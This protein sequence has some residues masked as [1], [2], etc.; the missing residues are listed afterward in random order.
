M[1][2][3]SVPLAYLLFS[4]LPHA[5]AEELSIK[6]AINA[7]IEAMKRGDAELAVSLVYQPVGTERRTQARVRTLTQKAKN[8]EGSPEYVD[9]NAQATVAIAIVKDSVKRLDGKA[10]F[11]TPCFC[12]IAMTSGS[13]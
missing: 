6:A 11:G 7:F 10:D 1:K 13:S 2:A 12:S 3:L 8:T 5:H 4:L 9:A